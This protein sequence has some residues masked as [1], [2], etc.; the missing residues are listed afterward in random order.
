[1]DSYSLIGHNLHINW[2]NTLTDEWLHFEYVTA[3]IS[4]HKMIYAFKF[5]ERSKSVDISEKLALFTAFRQLRRLL[6]IYESSLSLQFMWFGNLELT[7]KFNHENDKCVVNTLHLTF[8]RTIIEIKPQFS[9]EM[10]IMIRQD[11]SCELWIFKSLA[12]HTTA[13][14][15]NS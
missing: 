9:W 3:R 10:T 7:S 8:V 12:M 1:M 14:S 5:L 13:H 6:M 11:Q 4:Y 15:F 2:N